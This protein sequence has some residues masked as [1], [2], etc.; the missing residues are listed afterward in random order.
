MNDIIVIIPARGGSKE[1]P[2][3]NIR[4]FCCKPLITWTIE[5]AQNCKFFDKL[6]VSTDDNQIAK[7]S[8]DYGAEVPFLRPKELATDNSSTIDTIIHTINFM[9][10]QSYHPEVVVL[11]QPTSPLRTSEDIETALRLFIDH[12][13]NCSSVI[14]VTE[15]DHSPYWSLKI[16]N[17][18]LKPNFG[19]KFLKMRRQDLP[20]LYMPNGS[21]Y[22]SSTEDLRKFNGFFG[23][24]IIPYIMPKERSVDI[25]T[26]L[27]FKLAELLLG[28]RHETDQDCE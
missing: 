14:S 8:K 22:I 20:Q 7:I 25:D 1:I 24:K 13:K 21:I 10:N 6:I 3:K 12:K 15:Y 5:Q 11:L 2:K 26:T 28:E 23:D 4:N 19:E 9:E 17:E 18:Y 16:E 27:D